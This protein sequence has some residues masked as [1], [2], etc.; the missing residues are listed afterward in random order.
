MLVIGGSSG[1]GFAIALAALQSLASVVIIASSNPDRVADAVTR[2]RA[3]SLPGEVRGDVVDA[4]DTAA[5]KEF[6]VRVGEVDHVAWT[7]GD[8]P[9]GGAAALSTTNS[10]AGTMICR[11]YAVS[12]KF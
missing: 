7:A 5:L 10:L 8:A 4:K 1:I 6:A 9:Q 3:H 2:L 11:P 12:F